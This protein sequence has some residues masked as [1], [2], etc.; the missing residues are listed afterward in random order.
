MSLTDYSWVHTQLGFFLR[1]FSM[2]F[3]CD[4]LSLLCPPM[5]IIH[6]LCWNSMRGSTHLKSTI[7]CFLWCVCAC[8]WLS[9][10]TCSFRQHPSCLPA[11]NLS[12]RPS[13]LPSRPIIRWLKGTQSLQTMLPHFPLPSHLSWQQGRERHFSRKCVQWDP[14]R[15]LH[16]HHHHHPMI[17][18]AEKLSHFHKQKKL[19]IYLFILLSGAC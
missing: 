15:P 14:P 4:S 3:L 1:P 12:P 18:F 7:L 16:T 17:Y 2:G 13:F 10:S 9:G 6:Q 19:F 5:S 11:D 8:V